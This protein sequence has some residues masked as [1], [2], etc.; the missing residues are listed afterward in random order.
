MTPFVGLLGLEPRLYFS[1]PSCKDGM[2]IQLHHSP[3]LLIFARQVGV[4]P[5]HLSAQFW[6]LLTSPMDADVFFVPIT[7]IE[8]VLHGYKP[9]VL[10]VELYRNIEKVTGFEPACLGLQPST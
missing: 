1:S 5:T 6:R 9:C 2:L 7:R 4:E 3:I 10:T 8:L